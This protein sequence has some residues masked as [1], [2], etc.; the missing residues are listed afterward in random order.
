M[1]SL[2][3]VVILSH[4]IGEKEFQF[5]LKK[6]KN[7]ILSATYS[8]NRIY[9]ELGGE[10]LSDLVLKLIE[11][12]GIY[13]RDFK[14]GIR[15]FYILRYEIETSC[16]L[17]GKLNLPIVKTIVGNGKICKIIFK[18]LEKEFLKNNIIEKTIQLVKEKTEKKFWRILFDNKIPSKEIKKIDTKKGIIKNFN[19]YLT[20]ELS[21]FKNN[22]ISRLKEKFNCKEIFIPPYTPLTLL[23]HYN[24]SDLVPKEAFSF[25]LSQ[26]KNKEPIYDFYYLSNKFP[27]V[28]TKNKAI[29]YNEIPFTLFKAL[30]NTKEKGFYC[31]TNCFK[32]NIT[33]F[34]DKNYN[35]IKEDVLNF[36]KDLLNKIRYRI[37]ETRLNLRD[38]E[39]IYLK[40]EI[41][42][43]KWEKVIDVLFAND[44]YT[45]IF[46][47]KSKSGHIT[48]DLEKL[49]I[50]L[51]MP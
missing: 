7:N 19:F 50:A 41:N 8:A 46:K 36:L 27:I 18:N 31:Y 45:K 38:R 9:I 34:E 48:I 23:I 17:V 4:E 32:L 15:D 35:K 29:Y 3:L 47:I 40:F 24:I 28:E 14:I 30:E 6:I 10:K 1:E 12:L 37:L 42:F 33:F 2:E 25:F 44:L 13:L 20:D 26:P 51:R 43:K 11:N 21:I 22:L 16:N 39:L 5:I 49:W